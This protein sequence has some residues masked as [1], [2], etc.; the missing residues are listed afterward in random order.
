MQVVEHEAALKAPINTTKEAGG[1]KDLVVP[2]N[3]RGPAPT[4]NVALPRDILRGGPLI[5]QVV[6]IGNTA[7]IGTTKLRPVARVIGF[8]LRGCLFS[9]TVL[10]SSAPQER[11]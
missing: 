3:G 9:T 5:R 2:D 10:L 6:P 7:R 11:P 4:G 8:S 1:E